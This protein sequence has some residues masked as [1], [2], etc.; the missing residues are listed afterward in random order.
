M[1]GTSKFDDRAFVAEIEG[2]LQALDDDIAAATHRSLEIGRRL[3]ARKRDGSIPHGQW[4][5]WL[6]RNFPP[7][8]GRDRVRRLQHYKQAAEAIDSADEPTK[9]KLSSFL[10]QGIDA[11]LDEVRRLKQQ[12]APKPAPLIADVKGEM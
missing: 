1:H 3:V 7:R 6:E 4:L 12:S 2:L 8:N 10:D 5:N 11:L 9:T